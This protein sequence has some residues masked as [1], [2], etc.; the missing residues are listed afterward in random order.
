MNNIFTSQSTSFLLVMLII[1]GLSA[2][3][4]FA[5]KLFELIVKLA[6]VLIILFLGFKALEFDD[7]PDD[8]HHHQPT[9]T[10]LDTINEPKPDTLKRPKPNAL[11]NKSFVFRTNNSAK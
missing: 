11:I 2:L 8:S 6:F 9:P 5:V 7:T 3:I 4:K 10:T 1:F